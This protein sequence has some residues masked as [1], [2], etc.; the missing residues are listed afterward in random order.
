MVMAVAQLTEH[1]YSNNHYYGMI[2]LTMQSTD[3]ITK[4]G[5]YNIYL[6]FL[7]MNQP[8]YHLLNQ[9]HSCL[10]LQVNTAKALFVMLG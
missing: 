10:C 1:L 7:L 5:C 2:P 3:N 6:F 9:L 8:F 4:Y